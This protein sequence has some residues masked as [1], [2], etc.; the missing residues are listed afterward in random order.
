MTGGGR[1][2]PDG[3]SIVF[4]NNEPG[5]MEIYLTTPD[6]PT[7][8][9]LT[10]DPAHDTAP[11]FSRDGHFVYFALEPGRRVPGLEDARPTEE[12]LPCR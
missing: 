5:Q 4:V 12:P 2:S 7:P 10:D 6:G 8:R 3:R 11:S 1:W 9:R